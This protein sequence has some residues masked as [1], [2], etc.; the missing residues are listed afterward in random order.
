MDFITHLPKKSALF[1]YITIVVDS[2]TKGVQ[3]SS[4]E[5]TDTSA[6][7]ACWFFQNIFKLHGLQGSI[8]SDRDPKFTSTFWE[9]LIKLCNVKLKTS[10]SRHPQTDGSTK[11]MNHMIWDYLRCYCSS[12]RRSW[13]KLL[14][15]A[16]FSYYYSSIVLESMGKSPFET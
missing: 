12:H 16:K 3:I 6:G 9:Q 13:D 5:T 11:I 10:L 4:S 1:Y 2:I 14:K 15:T 8:V 7:V